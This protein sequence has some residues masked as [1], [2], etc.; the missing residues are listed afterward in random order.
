MFSGFAMVVLLALLIRW[1]LGLTALI[2]PRH[3]D[4]MAKILLAGSCVMTVSYATE[5]FTAWVA[6]L[7]TPDG[8]ESFAALTGRAIAAV[9]RC[10][11]RPPVVLLVA[12][13]IYYARAGLWRMFFA[14]P[15]EQAEREESR[16]A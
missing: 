11:A 13:N 14:P 10:T 15:A 16:R 9:N 2:T 12:V 4:A 5:W 7:L 3:F 8:A 1:G 6:G